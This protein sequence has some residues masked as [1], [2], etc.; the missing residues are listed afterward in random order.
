MG[1]GDKSG[2]GDN[3]RPLED[4]LDTASDFQHSDGNI[5]GDFK[6]EEDIRGCAQI[7]TLPLYEE[8]SSD[9]VDVLVLKGMQNS[10]PVLDNLLDL[11]LDDS[12]RSLFSD[13][14]KKKFLQL[15][16]KNDLFWT[17]VRV[18]IRANLFEIFFKND[19]KST[20]DI[21]QSVEEIL[22]LHGLPTTIDEKVAAEIIWI[23]EQ[24]SH[25]QDPT[26]YRSDVPTREGP[27]FTPPPACWVDDIRG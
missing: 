19:I 9:I 1:G 4:F 5:S 12:F 10:P 7:T 17:Q 21:C 3:D 11:W 23:A 13:G 6:L 20:V 14:Q 2:S 27:S 15:F 8:F 25:T 26:A 22:S 18:P 24:V 16:L